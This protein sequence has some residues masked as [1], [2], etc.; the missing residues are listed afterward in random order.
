MSRHESRSVTALARGSELSFV[1]L[2]CP[3]GKRGLFSGPL[4]LVR[5]RRSAARILFFAD[6]SGVLRG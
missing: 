3:W 1:A 6:V 4:V 2:F 5:P